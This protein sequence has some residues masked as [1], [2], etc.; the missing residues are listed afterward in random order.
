M[1]LWAEFL[2]IRILAWIL[3]PPAPVKKFRLEKLKNNQDRMQQNEID[4]TNITFS[5]IHQLHRLKSYQRSRQQWNSCLI[6]KEFSNQSEFFKSSDFCSNLPTLW[7]FMYHNLYLLFPFSDGLEGESI[8]GWESY[9]A[10]LGPTIICL[11]DCIK[12]LLS[13]CV[14]EH[15]SHLFS[16][17]PE[18]QKLRQ[19]IKVTW[20]F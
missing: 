10:G 3:L 16:T 4:G 7:I 14:P 5:K 1:L 12:L 13:S 18:A 6:L 20:V 15:E 19:W 17:N 2:P 8:G 11:G 9:N